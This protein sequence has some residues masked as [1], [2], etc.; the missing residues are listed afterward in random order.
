M[1]TL[2]FDQE[3][4]IYTV[5]G[6][7]VPRVTEIVSAVTGKDLSNIPPAALDAARE[8]G[9]KIHEDIENEKYETPEGAWI[10]VQF[11]GR[12]VAHEVKGSAIVNGI[13]FAGTA[14]IVYSDPDSIDDIKT[15]ST[16]DILAW[17]IQLNLYRKICGGDTLR[18]LHCPK[19]G[20]YHVVPIVV[21]SDEKLAEVIDA[22][23][24][25]RTLD[26]SFLS[27]EKPQ[28]ESLDLVVS[29]YTVGELTTNAKA[30]LETVKRNLV[31]YK[32]ENYS[33]ANIADAKRDK[34][35]L[36]AAAKKL[37]DKR[38]ELEREF[39]KPF[40][41]FKDTVTE[42]CAEIKK[43]SGQIDAIVREVEEREKAEKREQIESFF[44]AQG[45]KFFTFD[46]IFNPTWLNKTT[47]IKDVQAEIV[48][49]I[50]KTED[51]LL[52]LD[53][54]NE[55]DAKAYYLQTLNLDSALKR[56][57]EIKA[58][59]EQLAAIQKEREDREAAKKLEEA[60]P[61]ITPSPVAAPET[62]PVVITQEIPQKP[63]IEEPAPQP[64][65]LERSMWVRGTYDQ[66]VALGDYMNKNGIEF[67]RL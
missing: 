57:D 33:E 22:Y 66:I 52:I 42:T 1:R 64:V 3:K 12:S 35:E 13:L 24:E 45:C 10:L 55:P 63:V 36:N 46:Q 2:S 39:M 29:K 40:N 60:K 9:K 4:Q 47:K 16:K 15:Q 44:T 51:D 34:A 19:T 50:K 14:D 38:L 5:D 21:L 61:I 62:V 43:S 8:R 48:A 37:N 67:R 23:R 28:S 53:R 18:V 7:T 49:R 6:A 54:I 41:E 20:N 59:R 31:H 25:G 58:N 27:D 32:A 11:G 56:A 30:I 26:A 17:T 65:L